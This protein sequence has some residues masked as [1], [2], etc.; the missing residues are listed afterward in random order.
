MCHIQHLV[1][2]SK[3]K[4]TRSKRLRSQGQKELL[5]LMNLAFKRQFHFLISW[6]KIKKTFSKYLYTFNR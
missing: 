4:V 1:C 5:V 3:V 2:K 6:K